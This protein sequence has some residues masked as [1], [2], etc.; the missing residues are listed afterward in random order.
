[1]R[2]T[3]RRWSEYPYQGEQT[4]PKGYPAPASYPMFFI[5]RQNSSEF[6][7]P[8]QQRI[9]W[10]IKNPIGV[11]WGKELLFVEQTLSSLTSE[12]IRIANYW[13][14]VEATQ[15]M[16]PMIFNSAKKYGLGSPQIARALAFFHAAVNDAFV[17]SW[18]FKY[19][20]DVAR[21]N[22]YGRHLP[23]VLTTPRFPAY[24]S[25]HAAVAGCAES[26]LHY[27]FP[28]EASGITRIMEE[29]ALSRLYAGV[30]FKAD[31][32]EGLRLGRQIGDIAVK[33][34]KAQNLGDVR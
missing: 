25:A 16:T 27:F 34:M 14:T 6:L 21:P 3:Y 33:V 32:D 1:M 19:A 7:D 17:M 15:N 22:Q 30:H 13:G 10:Q 20:W 4:P 29:C 12:Q 23:A 8:F 9:T 5:I 26:V 11:D 28:G 18:Y 2:T 24:P 31:N